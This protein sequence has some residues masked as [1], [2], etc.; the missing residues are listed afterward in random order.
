MLGD[1]RSYLYIFQYD[2]SLPIRMTITYGM[3]PTTLLALG[4]QQH[5]DLMVEFGSGNVCM[6]T[7]QSRESIL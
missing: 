3:V 7:T 4:S 1:L 6:N 2:G 5:Q